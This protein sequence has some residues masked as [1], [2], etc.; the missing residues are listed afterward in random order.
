KHAA[1][2]AVELDPE[3]S[4]AHLML[5]N[6]YFAL[7]DITGFKDAGRTA[8]SLNPNSSTALA[9]YGMRLA[10]SGAWDEG[11]LLV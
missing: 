2:R 7:G 9:H 4:A 5:A 11:I 6:I 8:L 3:S 1:N 10:F